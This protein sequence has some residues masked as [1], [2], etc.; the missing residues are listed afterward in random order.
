MG[1]YLPP[2]PKILDFAKISAFSGCKS[3]EVL[4][5][6]KS[7]KP[8]PKESVKSGPHRS[9]DWSA[10]SPLIID[11]R[12]LTWR[13]PR[14]SCTVRISPPPPA[15]ASL[16]ATSGD[17]TQGPY[18]RECNRCCAAYRPSR[19]GGPFAGSPRKRR[20]L[21]PA[22]W[23]VRHVNSLATQEVF[24]LTLRADSTVWHIRDSHS[25]PTMGLWWK[26]QSFSTMFNIGQNSQL[27]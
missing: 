15:I 10:S 11:L 1:S 16:S 8:G 3:R 21:F 25:K 20:A 2:N 18:R 22:E 19:A 12:V 27:I 6:F 17:T 24:N 26:F 7:W 14:S 9:R 13:C 23:F 4:D 5:P